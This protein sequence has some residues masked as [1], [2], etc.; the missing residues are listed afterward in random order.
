[1]QIESKY[2]GIIEYN[3]KDVLHFQDGLFGFETENRF[4]LL[5][6]AESEASLLCL[7]S[8]KTPSLAF[9]V[10]NPFSLDPNYAPILPDNELKVLGVSRSQDLCFY[11][12]CV[13]RNPVSESTVNLKCPV[14]INDEIQEAAQVILDMPEYS[15]RHPLSE[16][17]SREAEGTC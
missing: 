16:F 9:V 2:F 8:I 11:V 1:M 4:L 15:M 6:F 12:L 7:Q 17:R 14:V 3:S 13:V 10:M 5:P